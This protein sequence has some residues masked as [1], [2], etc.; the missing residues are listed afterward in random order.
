MQ[1]YRFPVEAGHI[2]QFRSALGYATVRFDDP[3]LTAPLT[4]V[5][6]GNHYNPNWPYRLR[7]RTGP[8]D[9]PASV[10]QPVHPDEIQLHAEQHYEYFQ[11]LEPGTVLAVSS[12]PGRTWSK[13]SRNGNELRFSEVITEYRDQRGDLIVRGR[14]VSVTTAAPHPVQAAP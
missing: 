10:G 7:S 14:L 6:G 3:T 4:L 9:A 11:A 13:T 2:V 8:D 5:Q 12:Q 1:E